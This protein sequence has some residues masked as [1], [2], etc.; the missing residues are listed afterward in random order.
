[1][2][3]AD[4]FKELILT[5]KSSSKKDEIVQ[6]M[7]KDS[8]VFDQAF[9]FLKENNQKLIQYAVWPISYAAVSQPE[10]I[11]N[12]WTLIL[13]YIQDNHLHDAIRRNFMYVLENVNIPEKWHGT[14]IDFCFSCIHNPTEKVAAKAY[15]IS[16]IEKLIVHYPDLIQEF[17]V[18]LE[19]NMEYAQPA[20]TS[21]ARKVLK[22]YRKNINTTNEF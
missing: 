18:S 16:I 21:R 9:S 4:A 5:Y 19:M 11:K 15:A 7:L 3:H 22:K 6:M 17:I 12:K 10:L 14:V 2:L 1:M 8:K 20:F 13:K